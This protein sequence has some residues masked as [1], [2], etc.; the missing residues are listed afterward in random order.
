MEMGYCNKGLVTLLL[1]K[2]VDLEP[3]FKKPSIFCLKS[4]HIY[5]DD[6]IAKAVGQTIHVSMSRTV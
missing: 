5:P 3:R 4:I 6:R 1:Q 2:F